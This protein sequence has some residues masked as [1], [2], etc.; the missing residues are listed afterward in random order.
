[1]MGDEKELELH[2]RAIRRAGGWNSGGGG[3]D[4]LSVHGHTYT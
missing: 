4:L 1:M 2:V 3:W